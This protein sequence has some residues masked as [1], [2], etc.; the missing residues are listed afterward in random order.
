MLALAS[1]AMWKF[2]LEATCCNVFILCAPEVLRILVDAAFNAAEV[3]H[4]GALFQYGFHQL[5][6]DAYRRHRRQFLPISDAILLF[7]QASCMDAFFR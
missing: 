5:H 3:F 4:F 1:L 2:T 7:T 6:F